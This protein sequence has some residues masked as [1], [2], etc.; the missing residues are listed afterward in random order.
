M[1]NPIVA[2]GDRSNTVYSA[3]FQQ[4]YHSVHG[5]VTESKH[6]FIEGAGVASRLQGGMPTRVLEIGFGLGLN[7]LLTLDAALEFGTPLDYVGI[8]HTPITVDVFDDLQFGRH[9]RNPEI[10]ECVRQCFKEPGDKRTGNFGNCNVT[11]LVQNATDLKNSPDSLP[12][13]PFDA[14]YLDAFSPDN[15]PECWTTEF[16][17]S[18]RPRLA[19]GGILTTYSV[20]G[21]VRAALTHTGWKI[22]KFPG[23][24]G[25]REVL[26]ATIS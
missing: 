3:Q 25:K 12:F 15:N 23:P 10:A 16:F 8:E 7:C 20:K 2:T 21:S 19:V 9:L 26:R 18:L 4:H 6:V 1:K 17:A 22:E 5:A 11:V 13:A 24:P 14:I